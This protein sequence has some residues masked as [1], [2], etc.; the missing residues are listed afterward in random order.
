MEGISFEQRDNLLT[1]N[2]RKDRF[3]ELKKRSLV[4]N[5]IRDRM[6]RSQKIVNAKKIFVI[7][8]N[9]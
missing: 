6:N 5:N 2:T 8:K 9:C 7:L 4:S 3:F 1:S